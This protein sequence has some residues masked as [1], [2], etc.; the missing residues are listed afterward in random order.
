MDKGG[1]ITVLPRISGRGR[2]PC[3]SS[4]NHRQSLMRCEQAIGT[5]GGVSR[6][7]ESLHRAAECSGVEFQL[8]NWRVDAPAVCCTL[9]SQP[10]W[11]VPAWKL[12]S[13]DAKPR[14]DNTA[15]QPQSDFARAT[16]YHLLDCS[17]AKLMCSLRTKQH[18]RA[19]TPRNDPSHTRHGHCS[20][21]KPAHRASPS[22]DCA[23]PRP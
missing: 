16:L 14:P 2:T 3:R 17:L 9:L 12:R 5:V 1:P 20:S 19:P 4:E 6:R 23:M 15:L 13:V 18:C 10:K 11:Q 21:P 8:A 7:S 22:S